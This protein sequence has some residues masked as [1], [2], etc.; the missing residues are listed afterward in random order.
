MGASKWLIWLQPT[1]PAD[2]SLDACPGEGSPRD[3][4]S[5]SMAQSHPRDLPDDVDGDADCR[6]CVPR[7]PHAGGGGCLGVKGPGI[8]PVLIGVCVLMC[9]WESCALQDRVRQQ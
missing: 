2:P 3:C 9:V 4:H 7:L 8:K 5:L 1:G 6:A